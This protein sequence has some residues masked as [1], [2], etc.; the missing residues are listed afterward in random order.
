V[1]IEGFSSGGQ[2]V[3]SNDIHNFPGHPDGIAGT[4]LADRIRSQAERFGARIVMAQ[5]ESVDLSGPLFNINTDREQYLAEAVIIATG[6]ASR[7]LGLASELAFEGRGV[8]YCAICD[9][10]FFAGRRVA[11]VGGG[12]VALEEALA[13]SSIADSVVLVHRRA[14]FR[15]SAVNRAALARTPNITTMT[16]HVVTEIFGDDVGVTGIEIRDLARE[17][18][19]QIDVE[20]V[21]VAIGHEP[22]TEL[23]TTWLKVDS[24]GFLITEPRSTAT[25]VPGVFAA[26][27]VTDP[28]YRQAI[29]AAAWGCAAALDAERWLNSGRHEGPPLADDARDVPADPAYGLW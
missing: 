13:L 19:T 22:A 27:D 16:P 10:P 1:C 14:E 9:G 18:T 17:V 28:R 20:G 29:T 12:D 21:F 3:R 24:G 15:A 7:R 23:F 4:E 8:C 11:V 5:V 26:G 6:A 2:I 25:N